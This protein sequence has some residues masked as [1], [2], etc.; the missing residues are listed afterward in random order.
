MFFDG[1]NETD[2]EPT[3]LRVKYGGYPLSVYMNDSSV[4]SEQFTITAIKSKAAKRIS[5]VRETAL[6]RWNVPAPVS[7]E[8]VVRGKRTRAL[9]QQLTQYASAPLLSNKE[10]N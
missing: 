1:E 9:S 4:S 6:K 3:T 2:A 7:S 10:V 8:V 5:R